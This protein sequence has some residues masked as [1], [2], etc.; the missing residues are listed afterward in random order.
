MDEGLRPR[1]IQARIRSGQS[2]AQIAA[3]TGMA[4]EKV[5][6][7]E[8]PVLAERA[9]VADRARNTEVRNSGGGRTVD[10]LVT[11]ALRDRGVDP[12]SADW[13]SWRR[14]DGRWTV[15]VTFGPDDDARTAR[16]TYDLVARAVIP[17]D[18]L[19]RSLID[20]GA[21]PP[22]DDR[23]RLV[24]VPTVGPDE[25]FDVEA[26]DE[27]PEAAHEEEPAEVMPTE[28]IARPESPPEEPPARPAPRPKPARGKRASVPSWDEILF[29]GGDSE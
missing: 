25:V 8:A 12:E 23:P 9:H 27:V 18:D 15:I 11:S 17:D 5:A 13:D 6:R 3:S 1:D 28:V 10:S 16:W 22:A 29:G 14:D 21:P 2:S 19:A 24:S 4:V 26:A 7:F 20:P